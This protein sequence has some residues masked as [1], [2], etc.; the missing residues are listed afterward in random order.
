[1]IF[2]FADYENGEIRVRE[3]CLTF[4]FVQLTTRKFFKLIKITGDKKQKKN[5]ES[6]ILHTQTYMK[7]RTY[8]ACKM[9]A[10]DEIVIRLASSS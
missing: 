8:S 6:L 9:L 2:Q 10:V 5:S 3:S 4:Q 1:M 7:K